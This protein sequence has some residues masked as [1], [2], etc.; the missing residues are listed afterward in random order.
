MSAVAR[1]PPITTAR[2][3]IPPTILSQ[4]APLSPGGYPMSPHSPLSPM[5]PIKTAMSQSYSAF[6]SPAT[7]AL[8]S[9][10][11]TVMKR[12]YV[13]RPVGTESTPELQDMSEQH[14]AAHCKDAVTYFRKARAANERYYEYKKK[15]DEN[16]SKL[17]TRSVPNLQGARSAFSSGLQVIST[18]TAKSRGENAPGMSVFNSK[19][20]GTGLGVSKQPNLLRRL[21]TQRALQQ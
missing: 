9:P 2:H 18:A 17:R 16:R 5:T 12:T 20:M 1:P 11:K 21:A 10:Q 8:H 6:T 3:L 7:M 15:E 4:T 14:H 13:L 19:G